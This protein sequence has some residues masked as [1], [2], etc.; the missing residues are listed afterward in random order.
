MIGSFLPLLSKPPF[1]VIANRFADL[2][3]RVHDE[4]PVGDDRFVH[5]L[6]GVKKKAE[7]FAG[8][9]V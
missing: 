4:R 2:F 8:G 7:F 3:R 1:L 9:H 6:T 5:R